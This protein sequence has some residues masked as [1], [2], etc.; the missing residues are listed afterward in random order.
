MTDI[1]K[2][3]AEPNWHG[4]AQDLVDGLQVLA[5]SEE[6]IQLLE[7]VCLQLGD[8]LYPA[9][10]QI[11]FTLEQHADTQATDL[12][13]ATLVDCIR[14]GRLPSGK[15]SAWGSASLTGDSAFGQTRILGPIEYACAWYAQGGLAQPLTRQQFTHIMSSLLKLV[16]CNPLA[17]VHY[18]QKL[19][20]DIDDPI[21]G[22]LS[23]T[24]RQGLQALIQ[25]WQ[26]NDT[27]DVAVEAFINELQTE[28]MLDIIAKGPLDHR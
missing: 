5:K 21:S 10:L 11:L 8:A 24:T 6:Q 1:F 17:K 15:L 25:S 19:Q 20:G 27:A 12:V 13:A 18:C 23:N 9:F 22:A 14:T 7:S 4:A 3:N 28:S 2:L 26:N 16:S